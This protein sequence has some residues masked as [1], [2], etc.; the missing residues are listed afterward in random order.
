M[1]TNALIMDM[2]EFKDSHD[3]DIKLLTS[4]FQADMNTIHRENREDHSKI[5][6]VLDSVGKTL[7]KLETTLDL[8]KDKKE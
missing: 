4:R 3:E 1:K 8:R 7:T 2:K 6:T 5:F